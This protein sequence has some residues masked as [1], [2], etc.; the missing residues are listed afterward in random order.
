[1]LH[2][3]LRGRTL[4][5]IGL[6]SGLTLT[7]LLALTLVTTLMLTTTS[8][9]DAAA[10][11]AAPPPRPTANPE[12][13][14]YDPVCAWGRLADGHGMLIRCLSPK[15]ASLLLQG[16]LKEPTT[17]PK[18]AASAAGTKP[19]AGKLVVTKVGPAVADTGELPLA[20]RKL[21][22]PKNRYVSCVKENG[23][24]TSSTGV[25][26]VRFLVRERGRAEGVGVKSHT[27]MGEAAAKCIADVV[28][29]R[30][31]GYPAAPIVGATIPIELS[32]S[33]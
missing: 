33:N 32:A 17:T 24:L 28:D 19:G 26:V 29:R 9:Q 23:G 20:A 7:L 2:L 6:R 14:P 15:E 11:A 13:Y 3:G 21:S 12:R 22:L 16:S 5:G 31:V 30:Y 25:V 1:M 18:K 4:F 27:G 8:E 10:Q